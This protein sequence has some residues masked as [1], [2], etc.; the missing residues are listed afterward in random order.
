[1]RVYWCEH[2]GGGRNFGDQ[3]TPLLL[4]H[5]GIEATWT[6]A[7]D[8]SLIMVGSVLSAVPSRWRGTVLGTGFIRESMTRNLS[9]ARVIA[10]RGALTRRQANLNKR[11]PLGDLGVLAPLLTDRVGSPT[12][13]LVLPHYVDG[14]LGQRLGI[15]PMAMTGD[16]LDLVAAVRAT[17]LVHTSSL[18]GLILA[19]ALGVPHVWHK[20]ADVR[21]SGWKFYD[22]ASALDERIK[23]NVER[24]SDRDSMAA[25]QTRASRWLDMLRRAA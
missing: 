18:H 13:A 2:C 16:P 12:K 24:L 8:A 10:V 19:D 7:P 17:K 21:G 3:L 9:R 20:H 25:L 4:A 5:V 15:K 14:D 6:P 22:Y 23:P 1:M 11:I